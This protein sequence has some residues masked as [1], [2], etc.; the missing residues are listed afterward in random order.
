MWFS[1]R[2]AD[3]REVFDAIQCMLSTGCRWRTVPKC[4][5]P[6]AT[7]RN[8]FHPWR[9]NGVV[10]RMMDAPHDLAHGRDRQ[11]VGED[12][13]AVGIRRRQEG[14][15][16]QAQR[17][18][19]RRGNPGHGA[20]PHGRRADAILAVL[21]RAPELTKLWA[22]SGYR[23][24]RLRPEPAETGV[25]DA[26]GIVE[27][28]RGLKGFTVMCR[29]SRGAHLRVDVAPPPGEGPW[30]RRSWPRAGS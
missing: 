13:G 19:G 24:G 5:P 15:G 18:S 27:R 1:R 9:G 25:P 20:G 26:P 12:G 4:F 30:P 14:Q 6:S 29:R 10:E 21:E 2:S 28:P 3:L 17:D 8:H 11:P 16:P 7:V 23:G 22:D